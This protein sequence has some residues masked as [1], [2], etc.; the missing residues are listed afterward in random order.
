MKKY[1][2]ILITSFAFWACTGEDVK[3]RTVPADTPPAE[4]VKKDASVQPAQ[5]EEP[6]Q[7]KII[8]EPALAQTAAELTAACKSQLEEVRKIREEMTRVSSEHT[9]EN[10]LDPYNRMRLLLERSQIP[11]ELLQEVHPD[12]ALRKAAEQC[13]AESK[14]LLQEIKTDRQLYQAI[15]AVSDIPESDARTIRFRDFLLREYRLAGVDKDDAARVKLTQLQEEQNRLGQEFMRNIRESRTVL[16]FAPAELDGLP[17]DYLDAHAPNARGKVEISTDAPDFFPLVTYAKNEGVRSRMYTAYLSRAREKNEE[18]L[19]RLLSVRHQIA[20]LLGYEDYASY[21]AV[22]KMVR[23][24][25]TIAD[26]IEKVVA[27]ARPRMQEDL[28]DILAAKKKDV[29]GA[30]TVEVWDRFYYV[31]KIQQ[32]RFGVDAMEVRSYFRVNKVKQG[33]LKLAEDLFDIQFKRIFGAATWHESVEVYDVLEKGE[34]FARVYLDLYPRPN[35]Y[36]HAAVFPI[37]SGLTGVQHPSAALVTNFPPGEEASMDYAD[38]V[39]F[40]HEFGHL[41]HHI[42]AREHRWITQSGFNCEWDFV[43]VPSQLFEEWARDAAVLA[44][45]ATH[46]KTGEPIPVELVQKLNAAQEFGKGIHVMRQMFYAAL[47]FTLHATPP[48]KMNLTQMLMETQK[49]YNPYPIIKNTSEYASFGHLVEYSSMYYT[50]MW[51]LVIVK[52]LF[53]RFHE[54]G[55]LDPETAAAYRQSILAPGGSVDAQD[56]VKNFLGRPYSFDSYQKW[57]T[58]R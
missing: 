39:T 53:N 11:S 40:F 22:D 28:R 57:L 25:K 18:V 41:L 13:V 12:E 42:S 2:G 46:P 26:F 4:P 51:S 27:L 29:R 36:G 30:R 10:T 54:K 33:L 56:M 23:D 38:V 49:K 58:A 9:V 15:Q 16:E 47:S 52:D 6:A 3:P 43:E 48:D 37:Y 55:V 50:Y 35:K 31:Q 20:N 5:P 8:H 24:R 1:L 14:K 7:P 44:R 45:F 17:K 19:R 32:E 34:P 21:N